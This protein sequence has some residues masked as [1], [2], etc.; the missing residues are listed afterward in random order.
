MPDISLLLELPNLEFFIQTP[1]A[2][3]NWT[4][5]VRAKEGEDMKHDHKQSSQDHTVWI[6]CW[7]DTMNHNLWQSFYHLHSA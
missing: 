1:H 2:K 5:G 4:K 3:N 6:R 7:M